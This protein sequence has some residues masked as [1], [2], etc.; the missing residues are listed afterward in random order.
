MKNNFKRNLTISSLLFGIF[1]L[2]TISLKLVDVK[3]WDFTQV[4]GYSAEFSS[5]I[6]FSSINFMFFN[7]LSKHKLNYMFYDLSEILGYVALLIAAALA[8]KGIIN[9]LKVKSFKKLN[10]HYYSL[11]SFYAAVLFFYVLFE[12]FVINFRPII[13]NNQLEASY[14][15]SHTLLAVCIF[16]SAIYVIPKIFAI[17]KKYIIIAKTALIAMAVLTVIFRLLSNVHWLTDIIGGVLLSVSLLSFYI[18]FASL[19][20]DKK[21]ALE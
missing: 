12:V 17:K 14:P 3:V 8:M 20:K 1:V 21:S 7:L 4:S 16:I 11:A 13:N 5:K 19:I 10:K 18:T 15:S 9:L 6:G 2:F